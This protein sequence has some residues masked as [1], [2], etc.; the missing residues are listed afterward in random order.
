MQ[1]YRK[2][3]RRLKAVYPQYSV[4]VRRVRVSRKIQGDCAKRGKRWQIRIAAHLDEQA[5]MDTLTH[6]FAHVP[7]WPEWV[8]T[9]EHG[10][11]W[12]EHYRFC[13]RVYEQVAEES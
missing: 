13:Y 1:A 11:S 12:S 5:A 8:A 9:G 6:E 7:S 4:S 10:P 3:L 2:L